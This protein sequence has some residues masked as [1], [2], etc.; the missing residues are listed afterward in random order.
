MRLKMEKKRITENDAI[1]MA[2]LMFKME[3]ACHLKAERFSNICGLPPMEFRCVKLLSENCF[4][5][6]RELSAK[7]GLTPSRLSHLL[8]GLE[9]KKLIIRK[10]DKR[11]RRIIKVSLNDDGM[12]FAKKA[13]EEYVRFHLE[14][15]KFI[16]GKDMRSIFLCLQN[17]LNSIIYFLNN[18]KNCKDEELST[19]NKVEAH[20]EGLP[21]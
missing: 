5:L 10:M 1:L 12:K 7:M 2:E 14:L 15:L 18:D 16:D 4:T 9:K 6:N 20:I 11:N 17:F 8:N 19:F 13:N 3:K 21:T